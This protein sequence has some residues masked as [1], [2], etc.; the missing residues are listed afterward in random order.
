MQICQLKCLLVVVTVLAV[1]T[2][3]HDSLLDSFLGCVVDDLLEYVKKHGKSF[4]VEA[5][6][7]LVPSCSL[8]FEQTQHDGEETYIISICLNVT[9]LTIA[10]PIQVAKKVRIG[11]AKVDGSFQITKGNA[12]KISVKLSA[13]VF[14]G[15]FVY[16]YFLPVPALPFKE[17]LL[18][19]LTE[20]I[21]SQL[22]SLVSKLG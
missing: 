18:S 20:L 11:K 2:V 9:N 8:G 16:L 4:Y 3:G 21:E 15:A 10:P 13:P 7:T 22:Q 19:A 14:E 17:R 5:I 12:T 1:S 6:G